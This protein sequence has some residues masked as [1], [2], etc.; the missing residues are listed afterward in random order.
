MFLKKFSER[1]SA[2]V[3]S[4][5]NKV[6]LDRI[7]E[8]EERAA[9]AAAE[10]GAKSKIPQPERPVPAP[11]GPEYQHLNFTYITN[12]IIGEGVVG[13]RWMPSVLLA[14]QF[15]CLSPCV[16]VPLFPAAA[17]G[18][19][20]SSD[21]RIRSKN[22]VEVIGKLLKE[23]H[24]GYFMIWNLSEESYDTTPL[25]NQVRPTFTSTYSCELCLVAPHLR[26]P[27]LLSLSVCV[28]VPVC[29]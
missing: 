1:V 2:T 7:M 26:V 14:F 29:V 23:R 20:S 28:S 19:P 6:N 18:F 13:W 21:T 27:E 24:G 17:M 12:N 3:T 5:A 8:E 25:D 4:L 10:A 16:C 15:P 11:L 22:S 9:A